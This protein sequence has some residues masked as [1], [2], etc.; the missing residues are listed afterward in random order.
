MATAYDASAHGL[1]MGYGL[2]L[3]RRELHLMLKR[4]AKQNPDS[5]IRQFLSDIKNGTESYLNL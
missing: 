2:L 3:R 1:Q 4:Y 5:T